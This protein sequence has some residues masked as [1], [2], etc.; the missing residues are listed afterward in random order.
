M[1][2]AKELILKVGKAFEREIEVFQKEAEDLLEFKKQLGDLTKN[3]VSSLEPK[4]VLRYRIGSLFLKECFDYLTSS[5]EEVIHLVTGMELEKNLFILDRLEKV[6]Y[7]ASIVEAKADVK[8]LFKKLIELDEKYGHLLLAVFHSHPFGGVAGTCPSGIDRKLQDSLEASGY[9]AIQAVFSQ[10]GYIR[11]FSNKLDFEI[12]VYG[13][14]IEKINGQGN[15]I[16]FKLS[17]IKG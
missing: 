9:K 10:D 3:F 5:P 7:R 15:E 4:P 6:E 11:F 17:E 8:D 2:K 1:E 12:E 14:G 16:I 13:K